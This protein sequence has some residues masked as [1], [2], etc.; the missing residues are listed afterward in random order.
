MAETLSQFPTEPRYY[1][2]VQLQE[3]SYSHYLPTAPFHPIIHHSLGNFYDETR[4]RHPSIGPGLKPELGYPLMKT[5]NSSMPEPWQFQRTGVNSSDVRGRSTDPHPTTNSSTWSDGRWGGGIHSLDVSGKPTTGNTRVAPDALECGTSPLSFLSSVHG[6]LGDGEIRASSPCKED[7]CTASSG[8]TQ[9]PDDNEQVE[10]P[11]SRTASPNTEIEHTTRDSQT[12]QQYVLLAIRELC[13]DA[14]R[15]YWQIRR[16]RPNLVVNIPSPRAMRKSATYPERQQIDI[17]STRPFHDP[18]KVLPW[19]RD[20]DEQSFIY[21]DSLEELVWRISEQEWTQ[22]TEKSHDWS[23]AGA[24]AERL[25]A[26]H[27]MSRLYNWTQVV[28]QAFE[29]VH[30]D[31][32]LLDLKELTDV[33]LAARDLAVWLLAEDEKNEIQ[34]IWAHVIQVGSGLVKE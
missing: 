13:T 19:T 7:T 1:A 15:R 24:H 26:V 8:R 12:F 30:V 28:I 14:A 21:P 17:H 16:P 32:G 34:Q 27:R 4:E 20:A 2:P 33:M 23:S 18:R 11:Y 10:E 31:H 5:L 9:V 25:M 22:A 29:R 3:P 6:L